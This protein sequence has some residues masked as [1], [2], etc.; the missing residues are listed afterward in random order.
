MRKEGFTLIEALIYLALFALIIGGAMVAVYQIIESTNKTNGK[1]V[2]QEDVDFLLHKIN[3]A[4]NGATSVSVTPTSMTVN[5]KVF[6]LNGTDLE[7]DS[8]PLN[9]SLVKIAQVGGV[10][11]FS[12]DVA[13]KKLQITFTVNNQRFDETKY[14]H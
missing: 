3:W 5:G 12:Y 13:A 8:K 9:S 4:L 7:L 11:M 14:L 2:I 1:V 10:D 6:A